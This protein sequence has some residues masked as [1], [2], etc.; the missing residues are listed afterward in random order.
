MNDLDALLD[1]RFGGVASSSLTHR[2]E[3][4]V[5]RG[6]YVAWGTSF[7][8]LAHWYKGKDTGVGCRFGHVLLN[9]CHEKARMRT[10]RTVPM[11]VVGSPGCLAFTTSRSSGDIISVEHGLE[12][13]PSSPENKP[14]G[15]AVTLSVLV[16]A[17][18]RQCVE[19]LVDRQVFL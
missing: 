6:G 16:T 2:L 4:M 5:G 3:K 1:V 9:L 17:Q 19:K 11:S 14:A 10:R 7:L 13:R 8:F 15:L 18:T 12:F